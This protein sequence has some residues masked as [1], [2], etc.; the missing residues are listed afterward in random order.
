MDRKMV[1]SK[2]KYLKPNKINSFISN[3][4]NKLSSKYSLHN[5]LHSSMTF[6]KK[7][8]H[9]SNSKGD[10]M[11]NT[12]LKKLHKQFKGVDSKKLSK[13]PASRL[14]AYGLDKRKKKIE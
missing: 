7:L 14:A 6:S 11:S 3:K 2:E 4:R 12:K 5:T 1:K 10:S 9:Q 13:L 8:R